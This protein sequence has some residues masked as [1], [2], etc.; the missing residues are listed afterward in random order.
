MIIV[1][2][3]LTAVLLVGGLPF[4]MFIGAVLYFIT[5]PES[6]KAIWTAG[7]KSPDTQ[8]VFTYRREGK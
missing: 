7:K 2:L 3:I 8:K 6:V 5:L 4:F 1:R